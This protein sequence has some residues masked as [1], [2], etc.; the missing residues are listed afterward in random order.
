MEFEP[1]ASSVELGRA[2][3]TEA[4]SSDD[5]KDVGT[6]HMNDIRQMSVAT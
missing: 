2:K 3:L 1:H 4:I 6:S 5:I